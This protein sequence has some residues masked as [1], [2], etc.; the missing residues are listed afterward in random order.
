[1]TLALSR[2]RYAVVDIG[3]NAVKFL[4]AE[5]LKT[6]LRILDEAS[7]P[8]RLAEGILRTGELKPEAMARTFEVLGALRRRA[9]ALGVGALQPVA[10]SA[11]RDSANRKRFLRE[12]GRI[13]RVPVRV[14]SGEQEAEAI[15][16]GV[17]LDPKFRRRGVISVEVG[18]GSAQ[19][20]EGRGGEITRR[21][22]LPLGAVRLRERFVE[23]H[24]VTPSGL[25]RMRAAVSGQLAP[26]LA[27][28]V[29]A[30]RQL[31]ATGGTVNA[32]VAVRLKQEKWDRRAVDHHVF[33]RADLARFLHR[34]AKMPLE[35]IRRLPG[36]PPKREDLVLPGGV[37]FL[38][39]MDVL[40]AK[41]M[42]VSV[43]GFRDALLHRLIRESEAA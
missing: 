1:M 12:A 2:R 17:A 39:T 27:P 24:P 42:T 33:T 16:A 31:V 6:R 40:G 15:F 22:S 37:V 11:V 38:A 7:L 28:Y 3:S 21:L 26:A 10:T 8:T 32:L 35:K 30:G 34:L 14:L 20:T 5:P 36:L 9:D 43:R 23:T 25:H 41:E 13:L 4:V 18:G 29:M 19:W